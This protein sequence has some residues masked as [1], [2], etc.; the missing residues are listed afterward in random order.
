[1]VFGID[2]DNTIS[3]NNYPFAGE[4]IPM[5]KEVINTLVENGHII[6]L[7]TVR[8]NETVEENGY[9]NA[10]NKAKEFIEENEIKVHYF[11]KS[12]MQPSSLPDSSPK[13]YVDYYIDDISL[14]TPL[15]NYKNNLVVN[16]FIICKYLARVG[17]ISQEQLNNL[18]TIAQ[19]KYPY[20]FPYMCRTNDF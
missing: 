15:M 1:M 7:W 9:V 16:W 14:G 8:G 11:N 12:P 18:Q 19:Y 20:V 13:Q 10:L 17:A 6:M 5:A 2:F 4:L 3:T